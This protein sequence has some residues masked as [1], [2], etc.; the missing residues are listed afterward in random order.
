MKLKFR[1]TGM[2]C[3][4]CSARVEKVAKQVPGVDKADVN[5]L[6]GTLIVEATSE[7]VYEQ[8]IERIKDAGY[9]ASAYSKEKQAPNEAG[10]SIERRILFSAVLLIVLMYFTMGHMVGLPMPSWYH[11]VQNGQ[12][13]ALLQLFLTLPVLILNAAYYKNG[14]RALWNKSPNMDT[15]IAIGSG[16]AFSYSVFAMFCI[17]YGM[18]HGDWVLVEQYRGSLYFESAAMIVTLVTLGKYLENRAKGK[19]TNALEKLMNLRPNNAAVKRNGQILTVPV[20]QVKIGDIVIIRSGSCIPVDGSVISGRIFCDQSAI[21]GESIPVA[22][23]TGDMLIAG[24][25]CTHG[26]VEMKAEKVGEDTTLAQIVRLVEDAG[27]SKAP[28]ARIADKVAGIFVPAVLAISALTFVAWMLSGAEFIFALTTAISVLVISCPC[29]MGLA[30]PVAIMVSTGS[31]A[32]MGVLYKNAEALERLHNVD[33]VVL[34]KTGTLTEGKPA[35]TDVIVNSVN[36][37]ELLQIAVSMETY[38]EHPFAAAI[39]DYGKKSDILPVREFKTL[40]GQGISAIINEQRYFAGSRCFVESMGLQVPECLEYTQQGKTPLYFARENQFLGVIAVADTLKEDSQDAVN[41]MHKHHLDVIMLTGD[42]SVT[43]KAIASKA[44]I[45]HIISDVMPQDKAQVISDLRSQGHKVLM[46]GDGINDAA[47]LVTA[48][49]G[50]AIGS[51]TDIAIDAADIVLMGNSLH[52]VVDAI[53]LSKATIRNIKQNLFW[54]F[55]YNALGIPVAAG[56]LYTAYGIGLSP[57]LGAAAMSLSSLFVVT[58]ALRL[59]R[60][61]SSVTVKKEIAKMETIIYVDGMM[62]THC[63]ARVE[64]V[65]QAIAGVES[66]EVNLE[67][68]Y[69]ALTGEAD[70][71]VVKKAITDAGYEVKN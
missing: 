43:A 15:L 22:K 4:A 50:M 38:S 62:C 26:Y 14:F 55:F 42:N 49:V 57:M 64:S 67:K 40:P 31:G 41:L 44:G 48:D 68:K 46:V 3:A 45:S 29:A 13:A 60:F 59:G 36:Q 34:D 51:G 63:K 61:K 53:R 25:I 10:V 11:G 58:N 70:I 33:T 30:T 39:L 28:I 65:C 20:D 16:T 23:E 37:N 6:A 66:A 27:G 17:A 1:V 56:A 32:K 47:A 7:E 52:S 12:V 9:G 21:T 69:V 54:A 2:T 8:V 18:G 71:A 5:L 24:T 35:V 19:T